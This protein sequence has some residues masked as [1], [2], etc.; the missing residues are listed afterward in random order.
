M[1]WDTLSDTDNKRHLSLDG[2]TDCSSRDRW[3]DKDRRGVSSSGLHGLS[4]G[5][6]DGSP[7]VFLACFL[8][9]GTTDDVCAVVD[10]DVCV[11]GTLSSGE[12]LEDDFGVAW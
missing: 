2:F 1:L 11:E 5:P 6:E 8:W 4:D 12:P 3:W 10:G 7:E 9:V